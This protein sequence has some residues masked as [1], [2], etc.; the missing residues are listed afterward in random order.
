V[1]HPNQAPD[2][3]LWA[4]RNPMPTISQILVDVFQEL[5]MSIPQASAQRNLPGQVKEKP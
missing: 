1:K 3:P 4:A 5:K 2:M